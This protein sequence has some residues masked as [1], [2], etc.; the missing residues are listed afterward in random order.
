MND[1]AI[2]KKSFGRGF[3]LMLTVI[4]VLVFGGTGLWYYAAE[5][6]EEEAL[7]LQQ[8]LR[9]K[10]QIITCDNQQVRGYPFRLGIFCEAVDLEDKNTKQ[11]LTSGAL[12]TV[13]QIY[14]PGKLIV[15]L[16]GPA[17]FTSARQGIFKINWQFLRASMRATLSGIEHTSIIGHALTIDR[18]K[19]ASPLLT[20]ETL[21]LHA[22]KLGENNLDVAIGSRNIS[23]TTNLISTDTLSKPFDLVLE[24]TANDLFEEVQNNRNLISYFQKNGGSG[25][26]NAFKLETTNGGIL[27]IKGPLSVNAKGQLSGKFDISVT[28]LS[29][30]F[31][32]FRE[33]FPN[34]NADMEQIELAV[35]LLSAGTASTRL[36]IQIKNGKANLGLISLGRIP[37]LF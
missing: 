32:F 33:F 15:E 20:V 25:N 16:D 6:L 21:E 11:K 19:N 27:E 13:A 2:Q 3:W 4:G 7:Q 31:E 17:Q 1:K 9:A 14:D 5:K 34:A 36:Q 30:L 8:K 12:R 29:H 35:K 26:L 37:P 23:L 28:K 24:L 10:G 18:E 22:R